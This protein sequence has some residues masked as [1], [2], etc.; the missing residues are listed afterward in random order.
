MAQ[1]QPG[2]PAP[3]REAAAR[4]AAG[5]SPGELHVL[6]TM[7]T[8]DVRL[9]EQFADTS[10]EWKRIFSE[11]LGTFLLVVVGAGGAV[12]NAYSH[13]QISRSAAVVSPGLM[14]LAMI[15]F[16]GAIGG[17]HLNPAVTLAFALR[18]DFPW[19]R[20]PGYIVA[21][22]VGATLACLLLWALFGKIGMLGATVPGPGVSTLEATVVEALLTFGLVSTILGTASGSQ[23]VGT[24]SA[25]AVGAYIGL[26]GLWSSPVTGASMNPA[27]SFGPDLVLG[28]FTDYWVYLVGPL[29]GALL[30]VGCAWVLRGPGGDVAARRAAQGAVVA[31]APRPLGD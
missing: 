25:I 6:H 20:V 24:M 11:V 17:A 26:A 21:Q 30:A 1:T 15:L 28:S 10:L 3:E 13:G 8:K 27:R 2:A 23:N 18:R 31:A 16:M 7:V 29:V 12:V 19:S 22:L 14:V 9:I 5:P 4:A